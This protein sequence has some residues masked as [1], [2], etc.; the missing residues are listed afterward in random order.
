MTGGSPQPRTGALTGR[1]I[2]SLV[3]SE[4]GRGVGAGS[5]T[6]VAGA[7]VVP[8]RSPSEQTAKVCAGGFA[9]R[10]SRTGNAVSRVEGSG[11]Y[12]DMRHAPA[13]APALFTCIV[14]DQQYLFCIRVHWHSDLA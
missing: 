11:N 3:P 7:R 1:M 2:A 6:G 4:A 5:G 9:S 12:C 14:V 8:P 10:I 13:A